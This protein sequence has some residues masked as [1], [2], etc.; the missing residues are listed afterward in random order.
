MSTPEQL[1]GWLAE[2]EGPG[3]GFKTAFSGFHFDKLVDYCVAL[4][5]EGGGKIILGVTDRRPRK[6]IGT[7]A[8]AEPGRTEVGLYERLR[9]RVP[10][11][12]L[13]YQGKRVLIVH[14][15]G[16]LPGTAWQHDG[17][18]IRRAGDNLVPIP[19]TEL[20]AMFAE[21]GTEELISLPRQSL[22]KYLT[23]ARSKRA[24]CTFT[25]WRTSKSRRVSVVAQPSRLRV[26][27]ASRRMKDHGAG[28]PVNSQAR[29]PALQ[30]T[31]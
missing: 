19:E 10:V 3:L 20:H 9:H 16:R 24:R 17:R 2:P 6:V 5:N 7:A 4:A 29:T 26:R 1:A 30:L 23:G 8:F 22:R 12:E 13:H 15:P 21:T 25:T 11:E 31:T 14:V 18:Y 28:R 27:A